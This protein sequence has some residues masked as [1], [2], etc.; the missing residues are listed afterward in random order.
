MITQCTP[1]GYHGTGCLYLKAYT[2]SGIILITGSGDNTLCLVGIMGVPCTCTCVG[3][4]GYMALV[5]L[6]LFH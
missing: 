3:I 1:D 2:F 6:A 5:F 4:R